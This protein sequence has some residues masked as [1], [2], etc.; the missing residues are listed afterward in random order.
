MDA[1]LDKITSYTTGCRMCGEM[2]EIPQDE[3]L[4]AADHVCIDCE[5]DEGERSTYSPCDLF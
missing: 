5:M 2:Y 1:L 3:H 4:M